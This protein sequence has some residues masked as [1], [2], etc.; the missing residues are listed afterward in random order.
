M[1]EALNG[2]ITFKPGKALRMSV[3][4]YL[5]FRLERNQFQF[6]F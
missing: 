5:F 3:A 1:L 4:V 2:K 6:L